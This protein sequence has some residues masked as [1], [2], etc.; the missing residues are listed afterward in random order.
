MTIPPEP[1][2]K[3]KIEFYHRKNSNILLIAPH[4]VESKPYDDIGTAE[5][6]RQIQKLLDC[7]AVINTAYRKPKGKDKAKRNGGEPSLQAEV[8]NLNLVKQARRV[9]KFIN[10]INKVAG[11]QRLIF[12]FWIHGIADGNIT[13]GLDCFIGY[14]Q[15]GKEEDG[16]GEERYTAEED[17]IENLIKQ[18]QV[19]GI[20]SERAPTDSKYRGWKT[21]YMNQWFRSIKE[22]GLNEVQSIQLEFKKTGFRRKQDLT[23]TAK[24]FSAAISSLI[25]SE[26]NATSGKKKAQEPKLKM[27]KKKEKSEEVEK[28]DEVKVP[29]KEKTFFNKLTEGDSKDD[30]ENDAETMEAL[31]QSDEEPENA[32][33]PESETA[34]K[35][36]IESSTQTDDKSLTRQMSEEDSREDAIEVEDPLVQKAYDKIAMVFS[37]NYEQALMEAGQYIVR[38]FYGEEEGIEDVKYDEDYDYKE[39]VIDRARKKHSSRKETLNQLYKKIDE[40]GTSNMPS[41]A[42]IYNAINLVVQWYD[43]K[44]ELKGGFYTYRNLLLSHKVSLLSVKDVEQKKWLINEIEN[45]GLTVRDLK[46]QV[47]KIKRSSEKEKSIYSV[48][49]DPEELFSD[50]YTEMFELNELNNL[51]IDKLKNMYDKMFMQC[52][53][54]EATRLHHIDSVRICDGYVRKYL[55]V[56]TDIKTVVEFKENPKKNKKLK[57]SRTKMARP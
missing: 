28:P 33:T 37:K 3:E 45:K 10:N 19:L 9:R 51:R 23:S 55:D 6:T 11:S 53:I 16:E 29:E 40:S 41:K 1:T 14:G 48:I 20:K 17:T 31:L 57:K 44:N 46:K 21:T 43:M 12:V 52:K 15:P 26:I 49:K 27:S 13:K 30:G 34:E 38:T 47:A 2:Q 35:P 5:L 32:I 54:F 56:L 36:P 4:G 50:K 25:D 18:F 22:Y 24:Q 7:S 42:W 8:L 39:E